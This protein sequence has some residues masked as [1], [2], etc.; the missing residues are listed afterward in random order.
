[1]TE[2]FESRCFRYVANRLEGCAVGVAK[3]GS[4]R[5]ALDNA[6]DFPIGVWRSARDFLFGGRGTASVFEF[7]EEELEGRSMGFISVY[8]DFAAR[9]A[10]AASFAGCA[11]PEEL[12]LKM[13]VM[14]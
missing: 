1:M 6:W 4:I 12:A 10:W 11:S 9:N 14:A 2:D 8:S 7:V 3:G 5:M 13:E